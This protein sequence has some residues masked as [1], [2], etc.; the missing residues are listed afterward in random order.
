MISTSLGSI[1]FRSSLL[2][3]QINP[4][5]P[6]QRPKPDMGS[7]QYCFVGW[8]SSVPKAGQ[9]YPRKHSFPTRGA[10]IEKGSVFASAR[11]PRGRA[12]WPAAAPPLVRRGAS[13]SGIFARR[14]NPLPPSVQPGKL[15][16]LPTPHYCSFQVW[17][18]D[19]GTGMQGSK[20]NP[21]P[22][23]LE[24]WA[25]R[26]GG[27][28]FRHAKRMESMTSCYPFVCDA[29]LG[30]PSGQSRSGIEL[31]HVRRQPWSYIYSTWEPV[32]LKKKEWVVLWLCESPFCYTAAFAFWLS[33]QT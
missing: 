22:R 6:W 28:D 33:L 32:V 8:A 15:L 10:P 18:G 24:E 31:V 12:R 17:R 30:D 26:N 3:A 9:P 19:R 14:P 1:F 16:L 27:S 20:M 23:P 4:H 2:Y 5:G 7:A 13:A 11:G 25:A 21:L 29:S